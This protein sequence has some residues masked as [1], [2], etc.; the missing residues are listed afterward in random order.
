MLKKMLLFF[1]L[2]AQI[3]CF[4]QYYSQCGQDQ[5]VYEH[6]FK[7]ITNGTFIDIGANDGITFSNTY[8]FEK[9]CGWSGI[10]IEP[11]PQTFDSLK[12]IRNC[13]C[14]QGCVGPKRETAKF[15]K[16]SGPLEMLS[17]IIKRYDAKHIQRIERELKVAGGS[18]EVIDVDCYNLNEL[19]EIEYIY[20]VNF[21][22]LDTEG[23]ELKILKSIDFKKFQIDVIAVENNYSDPR[24]AS[25]MKRNGY[26]LVKRLEQDQI[27]VHKNFQQKK[28][29]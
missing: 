22:S 14:I 7:N 28:K 21:L 4:G 9:E 10:C 26:R 27:F 23:G 24:F 12:S 15:L 29:R 6:F 11:I 19:L 13:V 5:Y 1:A 16:I 17:G 3:S 20:H 2:T 8:F 18:Y 25:F